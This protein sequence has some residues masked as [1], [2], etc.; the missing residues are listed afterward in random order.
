LFCKHCV[1]TALAWFAQG[2]AMTP[3][4]EAICKETPAAKK[5]H[6]KRRLHGCLVL[7]ALTASH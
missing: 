6:T 7:R 5:P 3:D 2:K 1:A 4:A